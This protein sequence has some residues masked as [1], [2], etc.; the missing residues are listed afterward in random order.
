MV[1]PSAPPSVRGLP[2]AGRLTIHASAR[3]QGSDSWDPATWTLSGRAEMPEVSYRSTVARDV[4]TNLA[5]ERGRL[6]LSDMAGAAGRCRLP[7][8]DRGR[9]GRA[10]AL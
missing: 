3:A 6:V 5:I 4:S 10:L 1:P 2:I 9:A 8:P 7:G